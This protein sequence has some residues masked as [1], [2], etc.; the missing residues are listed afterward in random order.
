[1]RDVLICPAHGMSQGEGRRDPD[2]FAIT[3]F[4]F[5]QEL[6]TLDAQD[7]F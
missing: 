3:E 5:L 7:L 6:N 4:D 2:W 1:M